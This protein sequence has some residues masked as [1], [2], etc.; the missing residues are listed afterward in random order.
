ML[1]QTHCMICGSK[2]LTKFLDMGPQPNG[3]LFPDEGNKKREV[4]YPL[5]MSVCEECWL[6]QL[7][8]FPPPEVVFPN[9][10]YVTGLNQPIVQH[11]QKAAKHIVQ[12][13]QL[14]P[15]SLVVD[16]GANDGTLLNCFREAGLRTLGVDPGQRTGK[17]ARARGITVCETFWNQATGKSLRQLNLQPSVV[18]ATAVFYHNPDLHG[19]VR[20]LTEVMNDQTVF[21][22]QCVYLKDVIEKLEFDHFY[23]EHTCVYALKPLRRLLEEHGLRML[24]VEFWDVH[25][26]SF[27]LYVARDTSPLPTS[28]NVERAIEE[29]ERAGLFKLATYREF[30]QQVKRNCDTLNGLLKQLR[31]DGKTVYAL[32]A[33]V[34]GSTLMN[35]SKIGP[36]LVQA[37]VEV[38][39]FKIGRLTPG[40]HIPII[41]EDQVR[42]QPDY[43]LVLAWNFLEFFV[44][45]HEAFLRAGGKFIVPHP[46]VEIVDL[47]GA[48]EWKP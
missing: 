48:R 32:G 28:R 11:F 6:V 27:I 16:I 10:P 26:G 46:R 14:E 21:V 31:K 40:T 4:K 47:D 5:S 25:G 8:D 45:K 44:K 12:K 2:R 13:L 22:T 20:G 35:Y 7:D 19:F 17:L 43:Y 1:R 36:D 39:Q 23:H 24:D 9:H 38:N 37:V 41:G 15:N 30:A 18:T 34:K 42:K 29:E 33:P 3:N